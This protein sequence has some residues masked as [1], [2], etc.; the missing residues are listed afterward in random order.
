MSFKIVFSFGIKGT[1]GAKY[2]KPF[3]G[4]LAVLK[5]TINWVAVPQV[6][7]SVFISE[8]EFDAID[9]NPRVDEV[10][11]NIEKGF[12]EVHL[13]ELDWGDMIK[14]M[15]LKKGWKLG[16]GGSF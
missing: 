3:P 4:E 13:G 10:E 12:I 14:L 15:K 11:H 1:E 9:D 16:P 8:A 6:G 5:K 7:E 2:S